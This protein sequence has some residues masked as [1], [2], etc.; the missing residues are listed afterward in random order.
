MGVGCIY[1]TCLGISSRSTKH[2]TSL[3]RLAPS[4]RSLGITNGTTHISPYRWRPTIEFERQE[5]ATDPHCHRASS[6]KCRCRHSGIV[7]VDGSTRI[8]FQ[9]LASHEKDDIQERKPIGWN[10]SIF[11]IIFDRTMH[12]VAV[13]CSRENAGQISMACRSSPEVDKSKYCRNY[14]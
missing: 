5:R 6:E 11:T 3:S 8:Y 7:G 4:S 10:S 9:S 1:S 13:F 2:A 14:K 12:C